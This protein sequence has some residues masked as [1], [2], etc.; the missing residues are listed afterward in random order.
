MQTLAE[1][2]LLPGFRVVLGR[3]LAYA[4]AEIS[5]IPPSSNF[6]KT[7]VIGDLH[8]DLPVILY[9]IP[10]C[11]FGIICYNNK[12]QGEMDTVSK[13]CDSAVSSQTKSKKNVKNPLTN[14]PVGAII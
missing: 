14:Q 9:T 11:I 7:F 12:C 8:K 10:T 13:R 3:P 1:I 5:I 4:P 2:S 6:V